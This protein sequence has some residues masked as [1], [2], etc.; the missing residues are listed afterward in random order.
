MHGLSSGF[1]VCLF[2][3]GPG[4]MMVFYNFP[5][6]PQGFGSALP[7]SCFLL[8]SQL[9]HTSSPW[10][11]WFS[12]VGAA[13]ADPCQEVH[14]VLERSTGQ[15]GGSCPRRPLSRGEGVTHGLLTR[16]PWGQD[17]CW[18]VREG[19][20][21]C[22]ACLAVPGYVQ[23]GGHDFILLAEAGTGWQAT[24]GWECPNSEC[25]PRRVPGGWQGQKAAA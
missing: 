23:G 18:C 2:G 10:C 9:I 13:P 8:P 3:M 22:E 12:S 16:L 11:R 17:T 6:N 25:P 15:K 7:A 14:G 1:A 5:R 24:G 4:R 19:Y 21:V 20:R